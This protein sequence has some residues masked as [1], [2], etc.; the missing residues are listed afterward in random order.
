[1][2]TVR[3]GGKPGIIRRFF[4]ALGP[5]AITGAADDDPSDIATYSVGADLSGMADAAAMLTGIN[6]H[7]CVVI[8]GTNYCRRPR[9]GDVRHSR[10]NVHPLE[11]FSLSESQVAVGAILGEILVC[12]GKEN[13]GLHNCIGYR[14]DGCALCAHCWPLSAKELA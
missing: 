1:M 7:I 8:F 5:G 4:S 11:Q 10:S 13:Y 2:E 6:S 9:A 14:H 12:G 3:D